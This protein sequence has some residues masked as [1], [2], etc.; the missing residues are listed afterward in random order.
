LVE[1]YSCNSKKELET[2]ERYY[3]E[4]NECV[5]K[6]MPTRTMK[7]YQEENKEKIKKK[8]GHIEAFK[9]KFSETNSIRKTR[10]Y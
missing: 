1:N 10:Y 7:E 2:R 3:I 8:S 5:N 4:N 9:N 6:N